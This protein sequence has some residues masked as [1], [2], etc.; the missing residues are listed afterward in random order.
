MHPLA[1]A[2]PLPRR[3]ERKDE[4][5]WPGALLARRTRT[6]K[7]CSS[8]ARSKGQP[9]PLPLS[10]HIRSRKASLDVRTYEISPAVPGASRSM[11]YASLESVETGTGR[12]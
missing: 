4:K 9:R 3:S 10:E 11:P 1:P 8:D 7:L 12:F 6:M 5:E 2:A